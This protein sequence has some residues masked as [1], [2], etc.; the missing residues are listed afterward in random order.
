[1][2]VLVVDD[3]AV[4][5]EG[6]KRVLAR[7]EGPVHVGE[8]ANASEALKLVRESSWDCA[9]VDIAM[10]GKTGLELLRDL[11]REQPDLPVLILSMYP[12]EQYAVRT[13]RAGASGYL[14][15]E[16]AAEQLL[17]AINTILRGDKYLSPRMATQIA[18]A[19]SGP[20]G[21]APHEDLSDRE[22]MVLR[23]ISSGATAGEIAKRLSLSVKTVS[24]YRSRI[25]R[26]LHLDN[27]AQLIAYAVKSGLVP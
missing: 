24:T 2:R 25:L 18:S 11:L 16:S 21:R 15:K 22:F 10:P 17:V 19:V 23:L 13:L 14:T 5:R 26:K 8:A 1:M 4:V 3:H 20:G 27:T 6:L 7:M 12:E 9:L